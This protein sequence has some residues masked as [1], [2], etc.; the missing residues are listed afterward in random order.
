MTQAEPTFE[1]AA[2]KRPPLCTPSALMGALDVK[3]T[4]KRT[5]TQQ[6]SKSTP[7][8][9]QKIRKKEAEHVQQNAEEETQRLM[10]QTESKRKMEGMTRHLDIQEQTPAAIKQPLPKRLMAHYKQSLE[11]EEDTVVQ[12][13]TPNIIQDVKRSL[14]VKVHYGC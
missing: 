6:N 13:T 7:T 5:N 12:W 11:Y 4:A 14:H 8:K 3:S 2:E 10:K 1:S 9:P